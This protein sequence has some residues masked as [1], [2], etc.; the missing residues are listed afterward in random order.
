MV[1]LAESEPGVAMTVDQLEVD[2]W[3]WNCRNGTISS[4]AGVVTLA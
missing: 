4:R 2:A 1:V 3:L